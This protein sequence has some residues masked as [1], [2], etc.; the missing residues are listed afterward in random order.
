MDS[1]TYPL[2][3]SAYGTL[4]LTDV[5]VRGN[6]VHVDGEYVGTYTF[7]FVVGVYVA[8]GEATSMIQPDD[9]LRL[10]EDGGFRASRNLRHSAKTDLAGDGV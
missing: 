10:S 3:E 5:A 9:G 7:E 1:G 2:L 4:N 8:N 6:Y